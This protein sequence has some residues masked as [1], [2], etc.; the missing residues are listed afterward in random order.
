MADDTTGALEV[1]A[2]FVAAGV[3]TAVT[4]EADPAADGCD[5]LVIDTGTRR[6]SAAHARRT[7]ERLARRCPAE[8]L[9]KKTDST[10]RG[11]IRAEFEGLL[12][13]RPGARIVYAPAYPAQGRT[14][15]DGILYVHG[16]RLEETGYGRD[17]LQPSPEG[18]VRRLVAGLAVD[19]ADGTSDA[20]LERA[21]AALPRLAAGS[22]AFAG[23][24]VRRLPVPRR[25]VPRRLRAAKL[26]VVCGSLNPVSREQVR[27]APRF[28]AIVS[29]DRL[30]GDPREIARSLARQTRHALEAES[31]DA[32]AVFGGDTARA[33]LEECGAWRLQPLGEALP[34]VPVS[35]LA[36]GGRELALVTK[37]GGFGGPD[38]LERIEAY[39]RG[40]E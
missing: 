12:A 29:D 33:I 14:V 1:G 34:G 27:R 37:A 10:L 40:T 8:F 26:L 39:L 19:V 15:R 5:A 31:Y 9:F 3:R 6:G 28:D 23:A 18:S 2:L 22:G 13:A 30:A 32:L 11:H 7:A 20:D 38:V 21:A 35:V 25:A 17:P 4:L 36:S 16:Q 24:W